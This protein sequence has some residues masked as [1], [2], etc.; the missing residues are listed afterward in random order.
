MA[1]KRTH[2]GFEGDYGHDGQRGAVRDLSNDRFWREAELRGWLG[3][4]PLMG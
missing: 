4:R 1:R 2:V 3:F